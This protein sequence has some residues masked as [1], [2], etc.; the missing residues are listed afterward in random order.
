VELRDWQK[1]LKDKIIQSV[2]E[3]FLIALSSPTGS[4]KTLFSLLVGLSVKDKVLFVVRTHNEYFPVYRDLKKLD[5]SIKFSFVVGKPSAC[6]FA[7]KDVDSEDINCKYCEIRNAIEVRVDR[8]P[9]E[10]LDELKR[11]ALQKG[12]CPYYSLLETSREADVVAITYPYFFVEKYRSLLDIDFS[13]YFII[14]DEAHNIDR[15]SEIEERMLSDYTLS[16]AIKQS[17]SKEVKNILEKLR[18]QLK[19]LV[20]PDEKYIKLEKIPKLTN[21]EISILADEYEELKKENIKLKKISRLYLGSIL[22]FYATYSTGSFIPFSYSN[23]IVLKTLDLSQYYSMLNDESLPILLMSGTLPPKEYLEK[24]LGITRKIF[25]IDVEKEIKKKVTGS[26]QCR[27]A[28]DVT[29]KYDLRSDVMWKKYS[30]YLL[31]VYYQAKHHVLAVFPSYE[32]MRKVMEPLSVNKIIEDERTSIDEIIKTVKENKQK[33]IIAGV[34]KGK[35]TE[36]V[37]LTQDDKS[38]ISD[39]VLVGVPYPPEDDYMK[40]LS[41]K[42]ADKIRGKYKEFLITIPALITVKQAIGR[43]IRNVND[44]A[45]VW[46]LDKRYDSLWWKKNLNCFNSTKIRL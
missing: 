10:K 27:I 6:P 3:G 43:A 25:Y 42:I 45:E 17:R 37:E 12:F 29:S 40:M 31:K 9:L 39:V 16:M 23:R 38:L 2:E 26:Y 7:S 22:R 30:S 13:D 8:Y 35:I 36:G 5:P 11:E 24:V 19:D 44:H 15:V 18:E 4:G 28:I 34:G 33:I 41:Q 32:I 46:L 21:E 14:I 1:Q 20:Y